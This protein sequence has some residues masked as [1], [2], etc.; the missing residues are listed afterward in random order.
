MF[1]DS[2][3]LIWIRLG[4]L[5][6]LFSG[7]TMLPVK[8]A[9]AATLTVNSLADTYDGFCNS[10]NCTLREAITIANNTA[11]DDTIQF[12]LSGTI[13]LASSLPGIVSAGGALTIDG[14][15]Q[16]IEI[17][18][19]GNY[20]PFL[21]NTGSNLT[22][23]NLRMQNGH[24]GGVGGGIYN[25][26]T[27]IIQDCTIT[28]N[29]AEQHGGGIYS[30][31]PLTISN[32]IISYNSVDLGN[33]GGLYIYSDNVN[34]TGG[35]FQGNI[36]TCSGGAIYNHYESEFH[37]SK[38]KIQGT[39]FY[40]NSAFGCNGGAIYGDSDTEINQSIFSLNSAEDN[41]GAIYIDTA[42]L[43]VRRSAFNLNSSNL[44]NGGAIYI[45]NVSQYAWVGDCT[46]YQNLAFGNG[47]GFYLARG[48][49]TFAR[50]L[51]NSNT[52]GDDGGGGY[53]L[54]GRLTLE[55]C[56]FYH[57]QADIGGGFYTRVDTTALTGIDNCTF[58]SNAASA[59]GGGGGI[60]GGVNT[61]VRNSIIA[62]SISGGTC[63][64]MCLHPSN[65]SNNIDSGTTCGW[66]SEEG[67]M[68]NTNPL[69]GVLK[70]NGGFT[71]T[72]ALLSGSPAID[73]VIYN[74]PNYCP[75][76]DQ[77]NFPRPFGARCD[78]GAVEQYYRALLP[79]IRK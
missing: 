64:E 30:E 22:L 35:L 32:T 14:V 11:A 12:S 75:K 13:T 25:K 39:N 19:A 54:S 24:S 51:F 48:Y 78:I 59:A 43:T 67:S 60:Y 61:Q 58:S 20:R 71:Q 76:V 69:L 18:G 9:S 53:N 66:G 36:A 3:T 5:L 46:F 37:R 17:N 79:I 6:V 41:G 38:L 55:N 10:T 49:T 7:L 62:N 65:L 16:S 23:I 56:T 63:D 45:S 26:G 21:I 15:G 50:S 57:N 28:N 29:E 34:I 33:G 42:T 44:G 2:K 70:D 27:L 4:I 77:R 52:A 8:P 68:S 73:G 74:A 47:G 31:G 40:F 1:H 72:M